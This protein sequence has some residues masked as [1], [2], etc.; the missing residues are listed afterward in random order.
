M[1]VYKA[2]EIRMWITT[3]WITTIVVPAT[4]GLVLV[5]SNPKVQ[6]AAK[7]VAGKVKNLFKFKKKKHSGRFAW[8]KECDAAF[9]EK[10]SL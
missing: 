3:M 9:T 6:E 5:G 4:L 8:S 10:E 7:N 1:N 2:H